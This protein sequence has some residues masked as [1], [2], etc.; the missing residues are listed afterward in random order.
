MQVRVKLYTILKQYGAGKIDRN[1]Y[2]VL[3]E[4]VTL[5]GLSEHLAIPSKPGKVF[6]VNGRARREGW[7]LQNGDEIRMFAFIGGG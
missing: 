1:G 2:L 4:N 6:L 5:L 3:S 7:V